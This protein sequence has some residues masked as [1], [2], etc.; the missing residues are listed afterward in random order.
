MNPL[1]TITRTQGKGTFPLFARSP[2][3]D[4]TRGSDLSACPAHMHFLASFTGSLGQAASGR[5]CARI[6]APGIARLCHWAKYREKTAMS[7]LF[8]WLI[9][10]QGLTPKQ[11]QRR[12]SSVRG[13]TL[14][15]ALL[16]WRSRGQTL[17]AGLG[18]GPP[19]VAPGPAA[20]EPCQKGRFSGLT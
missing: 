2:G 13:A 4:S 7:P 12:G 6:P 15:F 20:P 10:Y 19:T 1:Q 8:F 3:P 16:H 5:K 18:S 11:G 14:V 17:H 9:K